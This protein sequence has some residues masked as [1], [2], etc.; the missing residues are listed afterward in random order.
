MVSLTQHSVFGLVELK[1]YIAECGD[2]GLKGGAD[3]LVVHEEC[4]VIH[5]RSSKYSDIVP[6]QC[7]GYLAQGLVQ[8]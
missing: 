1:S 3:A 5:L 8:C 6:G 2:G 7:G 4:D